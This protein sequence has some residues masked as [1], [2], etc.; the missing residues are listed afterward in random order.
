MGYT[1]SKA[2][3]H[4]L[5]ISG[6]GSVAN[7]I[8]NRPES[9]IPSLADYPNG[10]FLHSPTKS[11]WMILVEEIISP[12]DTR[13]YYPICI[14]AAEA[15][16]EDLLGEKITKQIFIEKAIVVS[17]KFGEDSLAVYAQKGCKFLRENPECK[18]T[19]QISVDQL[20]KLIESK[21][22]NVFSTSYDSGTRAGYCKILGVDNDKFSDY[23]SGLYSEYTSITSVKLGD[24]PYLL[25]GSQGY[26]MLEARDL[27]MKLTVKCDYVKPMMVYFMA[28]RVRKNTYKIPEETIDFIHDLNIYSLDD[29]ITSED[30]I[31]TVKIM[32]D[33][34]LIHNVGNLFP[35]S[36]K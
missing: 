6:G 13:R 17:C 25:L 9:K 31:Q 32:D 7:F 29:Y 3:R 26:Q 35:N 15:T 18:T 28:Y 10:Y 27:T 4:I 16:D 22:M 36:S 1:N 24:K 5:L 20:K 11:A 33:Q 2:K 12:E 23:I 8:E 30:T 21:E 14:S 19:G 34:K